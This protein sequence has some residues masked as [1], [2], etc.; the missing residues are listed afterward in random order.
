MLTDHEKV[1]GVLWAYRRVLIE[2]KRAPFIQVHVPPTTSKHFQ[3]CV[4][5]ADSAEEFGVSAPMLM[6][7]VLDNFSPW[8]CQMV[9]KR[10]YATVTLAV[11][12]KTRNRA[13]KQFPKT[14]TKAQP[15]EVVEFYVKQL[16][17]FGE[18]I[19][20]GLVL[21]GICGDDNSI[22]GMVLNR[23]KEERMK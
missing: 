3:N 12:E 18:S 10:N 17:G 15:D 20:T 21:N 7:M 14:M 19:A 5:F 4:Q 11:S 23:L 2:T 9:F 1:T 16:C 6:K 13:L 22:N 8:W